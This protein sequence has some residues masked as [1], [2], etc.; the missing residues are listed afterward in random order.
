MNRVTRMHCTLCNPVT[1]RLLPLCRSIAQRKHTTTTMTELRHDTLVA[2]FCFC[3]SAK[4]MPL[5]HTAVLCSLLFTTACLMAVV[6]QYALHCLCTRLTCNRRSNAPYLL[7]PGWA[8]CTLACLALT[9]HSSLLSNP[10]PLPLRWLSEQ[11]AAPRLAA[12]I[13]ALQFTRSEKPRLLV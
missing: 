9:P 7:K 6:W 12:H 11:S 1:N 5:Q 3:A 10:S 2:G 13:E 4:Q 8:F